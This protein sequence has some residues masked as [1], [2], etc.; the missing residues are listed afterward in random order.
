MCERSVPHLTIFY[1]SFSVT[2]H[3]SNPLNFLF[4][5]ISSSGFLAH[6]FFASSLRRVDERQYEIYIFGMIIYNHKFF[7]ELNINFSLLAQKV[8]LTVNKKI[9]KKY[10]N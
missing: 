10:E 6:S 2:H 5:F 4:S 7:S 3:S 1:D 8:A 9:I